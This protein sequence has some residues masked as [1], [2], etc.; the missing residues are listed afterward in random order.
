M[1]VS[2]FIDPNGNLYHWSFL[3][4]F[5]YDL[6]DFEKGLIK[7]FGKDW[8]IRTVKSMAVYETIKLT[9]TVDLVRFE[10]VGDY[11]GRLHNC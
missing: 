9:E 11:Y 10:W 2:F 4:G 7:E 8:L 6:D 5:N 3:H 1:R